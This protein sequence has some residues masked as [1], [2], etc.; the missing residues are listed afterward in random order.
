MRGIDIIS[1]PFAIMPMR[2]YLKISRR[3][4]RQPAE[5]NYRPILRDSL[6]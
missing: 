2:C 6:D 1:N 5:N 3:T 4:V